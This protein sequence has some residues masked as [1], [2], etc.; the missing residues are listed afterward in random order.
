MSLSTQTIL[1]CCDSVSVSKVED[2]IKV[3]YDSNCDLLQNLA[4][5][6]LKYVCVLEGFSREGDIQD[7]K[8]LATLWKD[9]ILRGTQEGHQGRDGKS[10]NVLFTDLET[11]EKHQGSGNK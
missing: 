5:L 3:L 2:E 10:G 4:P 8:T 11:S 7:L 9:E 6:H 1:L